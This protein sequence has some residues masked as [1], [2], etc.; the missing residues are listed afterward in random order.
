VAALSSSE[1]KWMNIKGLV[2]QKPEAGIETKKK[3]REGK[4]N[5]VKKHVV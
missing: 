4:L 3:M 2:P 5:I 1:K